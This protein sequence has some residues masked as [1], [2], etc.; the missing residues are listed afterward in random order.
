M[1]RLN[2]GVNSKK[3]ALTDAHLRSLDRAIVS[4]RVVQLDLQVLG[5]KFSPDLHEINRQLNELREQYQHDA[6]NKQS[7]KD[8]GPPQDDEPAPGE[9]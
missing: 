3:A 9:A 6:L 2:W 1:T 8:A 7:E 4:L 5:S